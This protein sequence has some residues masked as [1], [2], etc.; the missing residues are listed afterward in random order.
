MLFEATRIANA[1]YQGEDVTIDLIKNIAFARLV[2]AFNDPS[3]LAYKCLSE[4][5]EDFRATWIERYERY[6]QT[7]VQR[8]RV[9]RIK[10]IFNKYDRTEIKLLEIGDE[11]MQV[12]RKNLSGPKLGKID[13][14]LDPQF[15]LFE[16]GEYGNKK[17]QKFWEEWY[18]SENGTSISNADDVLED[19][20]TF[21]ADEL[22]VI[23]WRQTYGKRLFL[24][25]YPGK[26]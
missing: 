18:G 9:E 17:S 24:Y 7:E 22:E 20:T 8:R 19:I 23:G 16:V 3:D 2:R 10:A 13:A 26:I 25:V 12:I 21:P 11:R 15:V 14:I 4:I 5:L 6:T 1:T